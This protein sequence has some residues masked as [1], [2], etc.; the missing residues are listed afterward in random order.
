MKNNRKLVVIVLFCNC[1]IFLVGFFATIALFLG[2]DIK[3]F[4]VY[5]V[6]AV[7]SVFVPIVF[8]YN[9]IKNEKK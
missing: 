4:V 3:E 1:F 7:A 6:F 5:S 2:I 8:W 9:I